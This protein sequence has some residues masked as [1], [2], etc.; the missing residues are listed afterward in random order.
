MTH[1]TT[2]LRRDN[3]AHKRPAGPPV[4]AGAWHA[5]DAV[6]GASQRV[7]LVTG[8]P[9][10]AG[11]GAHTRSIH[12]VGFLRGDTPAPPG[13]FEDPASSAPGGVQLL[14]VENKDGTFTFPG[15]RLEPRETLEQALTREVWEEARARIA[16]GW[17][18]VAATRIEYLNRVPGRIHRFHPTFL[19]WVAGDIAELSNEPHHDPA[20]GVIARRVVTPDEARSLLGPL[21]QAVLAATTLHAAGSAV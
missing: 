11:D 10:M 20:D 6:W 14:L 3:D 7:R 5:L 4:P 16:P 21:E 1:M 12:I 17:R 8:P 2:P 18:P 15:G 9:S 19:L 13:P